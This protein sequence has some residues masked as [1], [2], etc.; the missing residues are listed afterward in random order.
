MEPIAVLIFMIRNYKSLDT[1][2]HKKRCGFIYQELNY[3]VRGAKALSSPIL[4]QLRLLV[5]A[6]VLLY[7]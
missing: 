2:K 3:K 1:D 7:F 5:L 6:Y 4:Y